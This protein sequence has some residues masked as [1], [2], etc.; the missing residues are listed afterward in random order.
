MKIVF[1]CNSLNY[2]VG[3]IKAVKK[4]VELMAMG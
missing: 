4:A 2:D 1:S 3:E